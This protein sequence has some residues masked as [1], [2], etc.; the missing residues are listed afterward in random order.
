MRIDYKDILGVGVYVILIL[1]LVLGAWY[2]FGPTSEPSPLPS[3]SASTVTPTPM[4]TDTPSPMFTP[5]NSK[6]ES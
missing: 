2:A 1:G 5:D 6:G 3:Q 4:D